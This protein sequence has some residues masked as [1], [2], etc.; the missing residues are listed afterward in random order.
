[1]TSCCDPAAPSPQQG[2]PGPPIAHH[3]ATKQPAHRH[4]PVAA[5]C[6]PAQQNLPGAGTEGGSKPKGSP[7]AAPRAGSPPARRAENTENKQTVGGN[8]A[9]VIFGLEGVHT[10]RVV[11]VNNRDWSWGCGE[12][13]GN[14]LAPG[15]GEEPCL[16]TLVLTGNQPPRLPSHLSALTLLLSPH[17]SAATSERSCGGRAGAGGVGPWEGSAGACHPGEERRP[18]AAP[19]P[20]QQ[21]HAEEKS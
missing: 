16:V 3:K 6:H 13:A 8:G 21:T 9:A 19:R 15:G 2:P 4:A 5:A 1:M 11:L 12:R 10:L 14:R 7:P 20:C 17:P 18:H